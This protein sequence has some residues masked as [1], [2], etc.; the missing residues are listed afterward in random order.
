MSVSLVFVMM[1]TLLLACGTPSTT[2]TSSPK[3]SD[4]PGGTA[5]PQEPLKLTFFY[6]DNPTLP[7]KNDWLVIQELKKRFNVDAKFEAIPSTDYATKVSLALNTLQNVPDVIL[8]QSTTGEN[9]SLSLNG[10]IVPISDYGDWTPNFNARVQE[11]NMKADVDK[12]R[13]KDGKHYYL[14]ALYD[15]PFY[16]GGLIMREDLLKKY[17]LEAPKTYDDLYNVLKKFKVENP[18]SYPLTI[19]AAPYV[20]YRM[21]MPGF[22]IS[23]GRSSSSGSGPLSWDYKNEKYFAGAISDEYKEFLKYMAKLYAEGLLDPEMATPIDG[24]KW[25][26]K[27]ATGQSFASYAYYDQ[28]GG[29]ESA[30]KAEG[31]KLQLY[32]PL[33]GPAG[34][35]HQPKSRTGRGVM[36]PAN[37]AKRPDFERVVKTIDEMFYS[38]EGAKLWALGAEGVSYTMDGEKVKFADEILQSKDGI[39]K[40]MQLK[41]GAGSEV[42]QM[43]WINKREML[44]YDENYSK[45]NAV[46]E[47]MGNVFQS[48]PPTPKF[49][50]IVAEEAASLQTPLSDALA[51]WVDAFISGKKN[52]DADW[53]AYVKEMKNLQ[54]DDYLKLYND[55]LK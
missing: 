16:D 30:A 17:S 33:E 20:L 19:L 27:L 6:A 54:I 11:F 14:P 55:N 44:K 40:A 49:D 32:P 46:V 52:V 48:I 23:V 15:K 36:F 29:I 18:S 22:G 3:T 51:K 31:F 41:Y 50:D 10:S 42:T 12:L 37:T 43:V 21:T 35:Y 45:I 7:F 26:Q 24:D 53:D 8:Y 5:Q 2:E 9:A 4:T 38:E 13:L 47:G 25:T 1:A 34:A 28:I 39:Y